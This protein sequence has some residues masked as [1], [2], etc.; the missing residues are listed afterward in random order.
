MSTTSTPISG[1]RTRSWLDEETLRAVL[2]GAVSAAAALGISEL[3][4][5][6]LS[7]GSS[8]IASVGQVVI[9]LQ[10]PGAKDFMVALFGTNDKLAFELFI[11][12]VG[13]LIGGGLGLLARRRFLLGA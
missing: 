2:A 1:S 10:P 9:G 3:L 6:I 11:V 12:G 5:G 4:A 7:G 13:T 8:L